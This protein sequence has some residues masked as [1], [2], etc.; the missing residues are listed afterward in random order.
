M[1]NRQQDGGSRV[2][3]TIAVIVFGTII[4]HVLAWGVHAVWQNPTYP[5]LAIATL[6]FWLICGLFYGA[7][8]LILIEPMGRENCAD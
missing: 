2:K 4:L 8:R 1:S 3:L 5:Q 7:V 6:A